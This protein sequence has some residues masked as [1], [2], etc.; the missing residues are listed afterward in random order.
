MFAAG[1]HLRRAEKERQRA[2]EERQRTKELEQRAKWMQELYDLRIE[3]QVL[4]AQI[5]LMEENKEIHD[6]RWDR[7][8]N[9]SHIT[10]TE[11]NV[12]LAWRSNA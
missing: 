5:K 2:E 12:H 8:L 6:E 11:G 9:H 4:K 1:Y 7:F 3:N 10:D